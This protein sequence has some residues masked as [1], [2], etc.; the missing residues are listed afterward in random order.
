MKNT[1]PD[2]SQKEVGGAT[3]EKERLS[4][5]VT[6]ELRLN[7]KVSAMAGSG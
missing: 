2:N 1:K 4:K 5:K 7:D 6:F 3:T